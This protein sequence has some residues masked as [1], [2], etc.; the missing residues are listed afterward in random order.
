MIAIADISNKKPTYEEL[1][2]IIAELERENSILKERL[3]RLE[4]MLNKNSRNSSKPPSSDGFKKVI[5]GLRSQS[6]KKAGG[7][8]GHKGNTLTMVSNP[9]NSVYHK[10]E[11]CKE[12]GKNLTGIGTQSYEKR[13]VFDIPSINIKVTE[14][15]AE[16]KTCPVCSTKNKADFPEHIQQ[17]V[18]YGERILTWIIYLM[19]YQLLPYKRTAEIFEDLFGHGLSEGT[20]NNINARFYDNLERFEDELKNELLNQKA[21]NFDETGYYFNTKRNWLLSA[22]TKNLTYY[23]PH[24]K[25]GSEAMDSMGILPNFKGIAIHDF[26]KS[27]LTF[28]CSHALCNV[29]HLRDLIF[30][31]EQEGSAWAQKMKD[32]LLDVKTEVD[33]AK[34]DEKTSLELYQIIKFKQQYNE[35]LKEGQKEHPPPKKEKGKRGRQKKSKSRNMLE[36]FDEYQNEILTFMNN[37]DVPFDNNLAEQDLRMMKVKQKIS[38]CFRSSDGAKYFSRIRSYISTIRKQGFEVFD[39]LQ[40]A[41]KG[42]PI[43]PFFN[44]VLVSY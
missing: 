22:S 2:Q 28:N 26:W 38:G 21:I 43:I 16:I 9:D 42:Q 6:N 44:N 36:R 3:L 29:H 11:H 24:T 32:F 1:K 5:K 20:L 8:Q 10:V 18:Q 12:C 39:A 34:Q 41:A 7:Q 30:C 13:Q 23:H 15:L 19:N 35:I 14:H 37:F 17:P 25:R 4:A 31:H 40:R 27:Y 33:K